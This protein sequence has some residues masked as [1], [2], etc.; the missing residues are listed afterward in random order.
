MAKPRKS[1]SVRT[2]ATEG[3]LDPLLGSRFQ[4]V[5]TSLVGGAAGTFALSGHTIVNLTNLLREMRNHRELALQHIWS[6]FLIEREDEDNIEAI[7]KV[8]DILIEKIAVHW[9]VK[10][11]HK[12]LEPKTDIKWHG[13]ED[14]QLPYNPKRLPIIKNKH[15][16][17][18]TTTSEPV[19]TLESQLESGEF[20][21]E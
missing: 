18:K 8:K 10:I 4:V 6:S 21:I 1:R 9:G 2:M 16:V 15:K 19:S 3:P 11:T 13:L 12:H 5:I 17:E 7:K 20:D 14:L